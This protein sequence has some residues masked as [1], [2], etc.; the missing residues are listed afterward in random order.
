MLDTRFDRRRLLAFGG[1]GGAAVALSGCS[2]FAGLTTNQALVILSDDVA[3]LAGAFEGII[4][5]LASAA[6]STIPQGTVD[7]VTAAITALQGF[8]KQVS[9]VS[10]TADAKPIVQ[11]IVALAE[12]V[13]SALIPFSGVLPPPVPTI[14]TAA[15]VLLPVIG[16]AVQLVINQLT[17][18][19]ASR[20]AGAPPL[21]SYTPDQARVILR[22]AARR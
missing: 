20:R 13:I 14:L 16:A 2:L 11:Q 22:A 8:A 1:I 10:S 18:P 5:T 15:A 21:P 9:T 19:P 4:P 17:P 3:S 12:T 6:G 7:Q